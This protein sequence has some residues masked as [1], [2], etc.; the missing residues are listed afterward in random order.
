MAYYRGCLLGYPD[1]KKNRASPQE[2]R[3]R[4]IVQIFTKIDGQVKV[5]IGYRTVTPSLNCLRT[6]VISCPF[7]SP[8]QAF[9]SSTLIRLSKSL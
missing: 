8:R 7:L 5:T 4:R 1:L 2:I 9:N 6:L 3:D